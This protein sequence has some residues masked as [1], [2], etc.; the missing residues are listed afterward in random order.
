MKANQANNFGWLF[1]VSVHLLKYYGYFFTGLL[2][3]CLLAAI[4]G[5]FPV[6]QVVLEIAGEWILRI[7]GVL[8]ALT[9]MAIVYESLR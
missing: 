2:S 4:L 9:M 3:A 7:F 1:K 6:M 5:V 8:L